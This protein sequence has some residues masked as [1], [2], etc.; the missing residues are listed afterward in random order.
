MDRRGGSCV[1]DDD[2]EDVKGLGD[3]VDV[4]GGG[5]IGEE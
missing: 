1:G 3:V 2:D 5:G 4:G